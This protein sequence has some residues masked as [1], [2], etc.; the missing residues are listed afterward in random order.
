MASRPSRNLWCFG[1]RGAFITTATFFTSPILTFFRPSVWYRGMMSLSISPFE[2]PS[3]RYLAILENV[4]ASFSLKIGARVLFLISCLCELLN[5]LSVGNKEW[6]KEQASRCPTADVCLRQSLNQ[7]YN[8][9]KMAK[10]VLF[11]PYLVGNL[12]KKLKP[13]LKPKLEL[14]LLY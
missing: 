10:L 9:Q 11:S 7:L 12:N 4:A 1:S 5:F 2:W 13:F 14:K 6:K 8:N 3:R